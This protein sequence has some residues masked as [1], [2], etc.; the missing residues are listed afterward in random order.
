MN[1]LNIGINHKTAPLQVRGQV[2]FQP[3]QMN[4]A[5]ISLQLEAQLAEVAILSTC[6]RTEIYAI[7]QHQEVTKIIRWIEKYHG[8]ENE[9][10]TDYLYEY[11]DI[12]AVE[13]I[14]NV[15]CGL[16]SMVLGEPQIL[17]QLKQ[18]YRFSRQAGTLQNRL[19]KLFQQ[20]FSLAKKVRT[21]TE[22]GASAVSVAFAAVNLAKQLFSDLSQ[23][24]VLLVGAGETIELV[25]KHLYAQGVK[26]M[27]VANRTHEKAVSLAK[28]INAKTISL[29]AI[30]NVLPKAEI[31]ISSTGSTLPLIGKGM[32]ERAIAKRK[33]KPIFMVDLAVPRDI[34]AEVGELSDVYLYTVDDLENVIKS[35]MQIRE[36]A[37]KEAQKM[38]EN[39]A[40][41]YNHWIKSLSHVDIIKQF[42]T[43]LQ[44]IAEQ[45]LN[46]SLNTLHAHGEPEEALKELAHR[47]TNKF[48]HHPTRYLQQAA[49]EG[50]K[51]G[52]NQV[53]KIFEIKKDKQ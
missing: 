23:V 51:E 20:T 43:H 52:A 53:R 45:E 4:D 32:V 44:E 25:S 46:H 37:K 40:S 15:S 19:E 5:L 18:S 2:S 13:H 33:R 8:L 36:T 47:L 11:H 29:D 7:C 16:D 9:S 27:T 31:L 3:E 48:L 24:N 30:P 42:R 34:E 22:I 28:D 10:L 1:L 21:E 26:N 38:I 49:S 35:N 39:G 12:K 50:N 41:L 6:N 17:G 14:M